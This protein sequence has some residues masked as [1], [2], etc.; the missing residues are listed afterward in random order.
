MTRLIAAMVLLGLATVAS[1][2]DKK[3]EKPAAPA[4]TDEKKTDAKPV[5]AATAKSPLDFTMKDID[6]KDVNLSKYKGKA[7]LVVNVASKCGLTPQYEQ[8]Q[9]L[10]DKY[11]EKGLAV[12][13][14]PAN[15]FNSQEP[16]SNAEIKSFCQ[17]TYKVGF[18]LFS[19]ISVKGDDTAE[20][21]KFLTSKEKNEKFGGEI[22][23]NFTKF[24]VDREGNVVAR[25]EPRTKP[26]APEVM[27]AIEA[28]L[29][30]KTE[31]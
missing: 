29:E 11:G 5:T 23:W 20:L 30:P 21:Y 3:D 18:D 25:F 13:A 7:V 10:H 15:N 26:D 31:K 1:A 8:L 6:G 9:Q 22:K 12:L 19:K 17:T 28:A 24:L 16:G 27:K 4:A 14:F 2:Q